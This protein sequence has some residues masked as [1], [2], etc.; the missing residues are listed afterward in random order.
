MSV[1]RAS[2]N[3]AVGASAGG[4]GG[5]PPP[6]PPQPQAPAPEPEPHLATLLL[7]RDVGFGDEPLSL[8]VAFLAPRDRE[9]LAATCR[10]TWRYVPAGMSAADADRVRCNH[11]LR[12]AIIDL[13]HGKYFKETRLHWAARSDELAR[14]R[15]LCDWRADIEATNCSNQT[16]LFSASVHGELAAERELLSRG[17]NANAVDI[18]GWTPLIWSSLF[19]HTEVVRALLAAGADKHQ[20]QR[21]YCNLRSWRRQAKLA[22]RHS[23][24]PCCCAL[25][26]RALEKG[27]AEKLTSVSDSPKCASFFCAGKTSV[28]RTH[29][30]ATYSAA[31]SICQAQARLVATLPSDCKCR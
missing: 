4:A 1:M 11:P 17:V 18:Y 19:G 25:S 30:L 23:R 3:A 21:P 5:P 20:R 13:K 7:S 28:V 27:G 10:G 29:N 15:E 12:Q 22:L 31:P 2:E 26:L 8:V 14:V 9:R 16:P 24:A 6:P